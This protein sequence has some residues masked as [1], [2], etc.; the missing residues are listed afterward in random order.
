MK[1]S[2]LHTHDNYT[3]ID[4]TQEIFLKAYKQKRQIIRLLRNL[5][6]NLELLKSVYITPEEFE[7]SFGYG[8]RL[9]NLLGDLEACGSFLLFRHYLKSDEIKLQHANFCRRDKFCQPCA[10]RRA[11]KQQM[12]FLDMLEVS[13]GLLKQDWYYI[14][15]PVKHSVDEP[16]E[17]VYE[18]LNKVK[19]SI[20][21]SM[22]NKRH[23]KS[24]HNIWSIFNGGM[25][26]IEVTK[27][28]NGWNVHL[29]LLINASK[30]SYLP[31]KRVRNRRGQVSYQ[32]EQIRQFL[33]RL[34]DSQMHHIQK[35]DFSTDESIRS[36]LVEVLKYSLKFS[37]LSKIDLLR[38]YVAFF[39]KRLFGTF[40]NL[41]GL[42]LEDVE[43][44][45]DIELDEEFVELLYRRVG[46]DYVL[47]ERSERERATQSSIA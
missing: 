11:Y 22:Q 38:V 6:T 45:G 20:L 12:K 18:R 2:V 47:I 27:T 39:Q 21:K 8:Q 10:V 29:N 24:G 33:K 23:R 19:S 16:I 15:I 41:R 43:L 3:K 17:V 26:S 34:A 46:F 14:V 5:S 9:S 1:G 7:R 30:G 28:A 4:K 44:D 25:W 36:A 42:K 35:L 32:N 13:P 40:G 31:L 37:S